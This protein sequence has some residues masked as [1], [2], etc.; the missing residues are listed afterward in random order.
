MDDERK[1]SV[2]DM[3]LGAGLVLASFVALAVPFLAEVPYV[4]ETALYGA[5]VLL[6]GLGM[7]GVLLDIGRLR[8]RKSMENF[9]VSIVF[10]LGAAIPLLLVVRHDLWLVV[11]VL[12]Y[13][14]LVCSA[15]VFFAF[16]GMAVSSAVAESNLLYGEERRAEGGAPAAA[17]AAAGP[18]GPAG[19]PVGADTHADTPASADAAVGGRAA[20]GP[21]RLTKAERMMIRVTLIVGI[22][23]AVSPIIVALVQENF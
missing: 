7:C 13:S 9:G 15:V 17:N 16:F 6:G 10:S 18:D 23:S 2:E 22:L 1:K 3:G 12:L 8:E 19:A 20:H 21:N 14:L 5:A 11:D 4:W